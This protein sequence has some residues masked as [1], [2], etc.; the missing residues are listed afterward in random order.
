VLPGL[1]LA[2]KLVEQSDIG[3]MKLD[4]AAW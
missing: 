1:T 2:K 4:D 3:L